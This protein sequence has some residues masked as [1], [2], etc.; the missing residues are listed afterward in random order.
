MAIQTPMENR[1]TGAKAVAL[2]GFS[3]TTL[4][5]GMFPALFRGHILAAFLML[6]CAILTFSISWLI[7]PFYYNSWHRKWLHKK[8]FVPTGSSRNTAN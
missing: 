4:F 1:T 7:F 3:W 5:F 6:V 8:G 2:Q